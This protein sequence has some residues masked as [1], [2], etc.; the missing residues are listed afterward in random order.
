MYPLEYKLGVACY[1]AVV[2]PLECVRPW[3]GPLAPQTKARQ[4]KESK[5]GIEEGLCLPLCLETL[6][7]LFL[8]IN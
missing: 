3:I 2:H 5:Q 4:R 8:D 7:C 1:S 6:M